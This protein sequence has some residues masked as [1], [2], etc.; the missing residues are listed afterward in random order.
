[1]FAYMC[2]TPALAIAYDTKIMDFTELV[3][4]CGGGIR[5]LMVKPEDVSTELVLSFLRR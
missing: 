3:K 4:R 1:V 5:E 2:R